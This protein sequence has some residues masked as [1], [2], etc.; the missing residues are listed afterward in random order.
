MDAQTVGLTLSVV[1]PAKG[2]KIDYMALSCCWTES[3]SFRS[4]RE[5][6][7]MSG[8]CACMEVYIEQ[9]DGII[10]L[11]RAPSRVIR[12]AVRDAYANRLNYI[13]IDQE[14]IDQGN[15]AEQECAIEMIDQVYHGA[16]TVL[17][18]LDARIDDD[19][20]AAV[21]KALER[22]PPTFYR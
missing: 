5:G 17:S 9:L 20:A 13:W 12:R 19:L 7:I 22:T 14:C 21:R 15:S 3:D 8:L 18:L 11:S 6:D 4:N 1:Q 2:E 10:R 16:H